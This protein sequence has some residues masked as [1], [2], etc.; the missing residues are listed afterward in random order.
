MIENPMLYY[1]D[2]YD[3]EEEPVAYC[4]VCD[5]P[6]YDSEVYFIDD[7]SN[8]IHEDC[9]FKY[10]KEFYTVA[11]IATEMGLRKHDHHI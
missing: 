11:E 9:F 5:K 7:V 2:R 10:L 8:Y 4:A 1:A 6:I 3:P